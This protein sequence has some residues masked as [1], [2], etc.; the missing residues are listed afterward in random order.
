RHPAQTPR[1]P[2]PIQQPLFPGGSF[3][4]ALG[5]EGGQGAALQPGASCHLPTLP[6][7][8]P[9]LLLEAGYGVPPK[10]RR[11]RTAFSL[12]QLQ[13]LERAFEKSHYPDVATRERLALGINLPEA[14]VQV[15]FKNRRAKFRKSQR[16]RLEM[17]AS[18]S[19]RQGR[20]PGSPPSEPSR[21]PAWKAMTEPLRWCLLEEP[22]L[23]VLAGTWL[24]GELKRG[25]RT[26]RPS[27]LL[28][29]PFAAYQLPAPG[30]PAAPGAL[31]AVSSWT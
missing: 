25:Q 14:R 26:L 21:V 23:R 9:E 16:R 20:G 1:G 7:P 5:T 31:P 6:A 13:A 19:P 12:H 10:H 29:L 2:S 27:C 24:A 18:A 3:H 17:G 8:S 4:P 30:L 15:W 11:S 28:A 22:R